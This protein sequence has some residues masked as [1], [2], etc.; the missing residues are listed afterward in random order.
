[1]SLFKADNL[2]SLKEF[3]DTGYKLGILKR[4]QP[5]AADSFFQKLI[6]ND[7]KIDGTISLINLREDLENLVQEIIPDQLSSSDFYNYWL[8]DMETV[9]R[10]FLLIE[11][12]DSLCFWL[13]T[14]R[15]CRRYH[16][17]NVPRRLLVTYAGQGTEWI[18]NQDADLKAYE[19]G[20]PNEKIVRDKSK[21][22]F[23]DTWNIAIFTGGSDGIL[24]RTPDSA[25][26]GPSILMRLDHP[27]FL[28][29]VYSSEVLKLN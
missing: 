27:E 7:F 3:K 23:I 10:T 12:T 21:L 29:S 14:K 11:K 22:N 8:S 2:E 24:H 17:D 26:N 20:E 4:E 5:E 28:D 6:K 25:L 15:E 9:C 18:Q 16:I 19:A 1:M 13:G